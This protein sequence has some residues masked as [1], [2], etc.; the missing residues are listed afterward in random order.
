VSDVPPPGG[1]PPQQ[2][3]YQPPAAPPP[4]PGGYQP[5]AAPQ[6]QPPAAPAPP[7][8]QAPPAAPPPG[9][10]AAP[11]YQQPGQFQP[12][13]PAPPTS[14]GNGC[15]KAFLIVL[16]VVVVLGIVGTIGVVV[17]VGKSVD[18]ISK[19]FGTADVGDYDVSVDK[20]D[21][22]GTTGIMTASGTFTNKADRTQAYS[23][24][25]TF[26]T[27][28]NT[29]LGEEGFIDTGSLTQ[30]QK[31]QFNATNTSTIGGNA[32]NVIKCQVTSVNYFGS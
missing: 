2:P 13:N 8:Y 24:T 14:S 11:A 4:Q 26:S 9:A 5:P 6:Y 17:L 22:D 23:I 29:K 25:V 20:C 21:I 30:G 32:P 18:T 28:D 16:A 31:Y 1:Y 19:T 7:P 12:V 3:G 10:P 27:A 15:L